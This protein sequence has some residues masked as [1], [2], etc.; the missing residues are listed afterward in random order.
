VFGET[1]EQVPVD[2]A[3][4]PVKVNVNRVHG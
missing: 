1:A 3:A 2:P 4:P